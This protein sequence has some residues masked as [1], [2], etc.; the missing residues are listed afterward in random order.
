MLDPALPRF[1]GDF[2]VDTLAELARI[3]RAVKSLRFSSEFDA[4]HQPGHDSYTELARPVILTLIISLENG[5][6]Q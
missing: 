4:F 5:A 6:A 2:F 1:L 3:R